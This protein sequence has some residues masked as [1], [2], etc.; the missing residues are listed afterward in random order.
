MGESNLNEEHFEHPS[1]AV[2]NINRAQIGGGSKRLFDSP[3]KHYNVITLSISPAKCIRKLHG[4]NIFP[5]GEVPHIEVAM[6]EVQ[7]ANLMLNAN[8]HG[9][10][11]CTVETIKGKRVGEPPANNLKKLWATEVKRD[12]RDVAEGAMKVEKEIDDLLSKDRV[13]KADLKKIKDTISMVAQDIRENLPWMQQRFEEAME[14]TVS[15]AK[16]EIDAHLANTVKRHGL[17]HL[18]KEGQLPR[19]EM[20]QGEKGD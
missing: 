6:S 2:I 11:P 4:D 18:Q 9:G 5:T 14:K 17:Q 1:Y 8:M 16:A 10:T 20:Q 12:F 15:V 7:F 3:F 19:I 13:T